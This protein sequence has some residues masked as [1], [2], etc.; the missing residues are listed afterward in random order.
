[1]SWQRISIWDP[2]IQSSFF[3]QN[4]TVSICLG[5]FCGKNS[6]TRTET[7]PPDC[8]CHGLRSR[9]Q[10]RL[11]NQ[12]H[13]GLQVQQL[14]MG[15]TALASPSSES[16]YIALVLKVSSSF[17]TSTLP[18]AGAGK[19]SREKTQALRLFLSSALSLPDVADRLC[20]PSAKTA[21]YV[22]SKAVRDGVVDASI[23]HEE[24]YVQSHDFESMS[25]P[26]K[27]RPKPFIAVLPIV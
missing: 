16:I 5:Y 15:P 23:H 8:A 1:M 14:P 13:L 3:K 2:I 21:E 18:G 4:N 10:A 11:W 20:L 25:T 19:P 27:N 7:A 12:L 17:C 26:R 6:A 9:L 24:S 22:V